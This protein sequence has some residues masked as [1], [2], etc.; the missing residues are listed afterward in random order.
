MALRRR[1]SSSSLRQQQQAAVQPPLHRL[2]RDAQ[3]LGGLGLR[4]SLDPHQVEDLPLVLRQAVDRRQ[5]AAAVRGEAGV[6][7]GRGRHQ[8]LA[9]LDGGGLFI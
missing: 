7:A 8:P 3:H 6:A 1:R 9:Q 4:Q 5:H 2:G